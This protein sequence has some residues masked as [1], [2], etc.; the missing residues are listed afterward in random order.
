M[1][2]EL[3]ADLRRRSNDKKFNKYALNKVYKSQK[4][5]QKLEEKEVFA[6]SLKVGDVIKMKN[7]CMIPTDCIVIQTDDPL[8]QCYINTA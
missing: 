6:E 7:G 3:V 2:F 4:D 1:L 5:S 8:G